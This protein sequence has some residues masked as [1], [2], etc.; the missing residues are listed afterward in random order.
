MLWGTALA[1]MERD[2]VKALIQQYVQGE[3][4][5]RITFQEAYGPLIYSF[6]VRF[7]HLQESD[8]G[9]FYLYAFETSELF[10]S[11]S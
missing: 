4:A 6:P 10:V 9:A 1:Q 5:A 7:F 2:A 3:I 8:A 11:Y